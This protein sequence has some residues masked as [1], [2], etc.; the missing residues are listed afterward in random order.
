MMMMMKMLMLLLQGFNNGLEPNVCGYRVDLSFFNAKDETCGDCGD[1][2]LADVRLGD[3]DEF[4]VHGIV[5][6]G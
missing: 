4:L 2:S 1:F 3:G 5:V 6:V